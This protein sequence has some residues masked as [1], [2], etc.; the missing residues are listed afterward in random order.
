MSNLFFALAA[1]R[2]WVRHT[3]VATATVAVMTACTT[4][5]RPSNPDT[6]E[7]PTVHNGVIAYVE[8]LAGPEY[9]QPPGS[10]ASL[11]PQI[12]LP[13][14]LDVSFL[15]WSPDGRYLAYVVGKYFLRRS[16]IAVLDVETGETQRLTSGSSD[17]SPIWSPD[18]RRIAFLR[19][20]QGSAALW[21]I[22]HDGSDARAVTSPREGPWKPFRDPNVV[23][24]RP[25]VI[26]PGTVVRAIAWSP[27]SER[28]AF[29]VDPFG[30]QPEV[31]I[32]PL[33]GEVE[34]IILEGSYPSW[35]PDGNRLCL[36]QR[37][38]SGTRLVTISPD[39][40]ERDVIT[41]G[42]ATHTMPRW[43]PDGAS[44]LYLS[45]EEGPPGK[46]ELWVI[47]SD[48][49]EPKQI[50]TDATELT[51]HNPWELYPSWSPDGSLIVYLDQI[52]GGGAVDEWVSVV[53][54]N[55]G[56]PETLTQSESDWP[57]WQPIRV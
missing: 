17:A 55:G 52:F 27:D 29:A 28:I 6:A 22:N 49:S 34:P 10:S 35:S 39:G 26:D 25:K 14:A 33:D 8:F 24:P 43:S 21:V 20:S 40:T 44:I 13:D 47:G 36:V 12:K 37:T 42:S 23:F 7:G 38:S 57:A 50:T 45:D 18:G 53:S 51:G 54:P 56:P 48:G 16:S 31:A 1:P 32:V 9:L 19:F 5:D 41:E 11:P 30:D 4:H 46:L 15:D 3:T 2:G